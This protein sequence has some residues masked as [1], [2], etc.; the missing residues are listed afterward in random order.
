MISVHGLLPH[1]VFSF[2]GRQ[3]AICQIFRS[4]ITFECLL[5]SNSCYNI[6]ENKL[7]KSNLCRSMLMRS[8]VRL[9]VLVGFTVFFSCRPRAQSLLST[10][11]SP[12]NSAAILSAIED[13]K[14][15]GTSQPRDTLAQTTRQLQIFGDSCGYKDSK[16]FP[17]RSTSAPRGF[18]DEGGGF[19]RAMARPHLSCTS[20]ERVE[21]KTCVQ[22]Y[23]IQF[24]PTVKAGQENHFLVANTSPIIRLIPRLS[25]P[26]GTKLCTFQKDTAL[27]WVAGV[28]NPSVGTTWENTDIELLSALM[29]WNRNTDAPVL[30][31][32]R[33]NAKLTS[34]PGYLQIVDNHGNAA[35]GLFGGHDSLSIRRLANNMQLAFRAGI[36]QIEVVSHSNGAITT[37]MGVQLFLN[38]LSSSE[39]AWKSD[40]KK[41]VGAKD[42]MRV[43]IFHLQAA[44]T[45][46]WSLTTLD[47]FNSNSD[48]FKNAVWVRRVKLGVPYWGW[49]WDFAVYD[50]AQK[51]LDLQVRIF[52]NSPDFWTFPM[53]NPAG[54]PISI[55]WHKEVIA[56]GLSRGVKTT[57]QHYKCDASSA[58]S[59][60]GPEHSQRTSL[61]AFSDLSEVMPWSGELS[62]VNGS[63]E[64]LASPSATTTSSVAA[65]QS[66]NP[67]EKNATIKNSKLAMAKMVCL[68]L[69]KH[70]ALC[71]ELAQKP[72][73]SDNGLP[74]FLCAPKDEQN[75][76]CTRTE[77]WDGICSLPEQTD[78]MLRKTECY[79]PTQISTCECNGTACNTINISC[80]EKGCTNTKKATV[81]QC[82]CQ[83]TPGATVPCPAGI[84]YCRTDKIAN[85]CWRTTAQSRV[86]GVLKYEFCKGPECMAPAAAQRAMAPSTESAAAVGEE[87]VLPVKTKLILKNSR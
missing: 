30:G 7:K 71:T 4:A 20:E 5:F 83:E 50:K 37:Q 14:Y 21:G 18:F 41:S 24:F 61:W 9:F 77:P 64:S 54:R 17:F 51:F 49:D 59:A 32:S 15:T 75:H 23:G 62:N 28:N 6:A 76:P 16:V 53:I 66:M 39:A 67:L 13:T 69:E 60:C 22:E 70:K 63:A 46:K 36:N 38:E 57:V 47:D 29:A 1:T 8:C 74:L 45:Q 2:I 25:Y 55:A 80:G 56:E 33:A 82:T 12:A 34:A 31:G 85:Q 68:D 44:P 10:A 19:W 40:R 87:D 3:L 11:A 26:D 48:F 78:A 58:L 42:V 27:I 84:A 43:R 65:A 81:P 52:Y 86:P 79:V 35:S 72:N 73:L